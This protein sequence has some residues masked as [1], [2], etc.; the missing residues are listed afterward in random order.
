[1]LL[2]FYALRYQFLKTTWILVFHCI[3]VADLVNLTLYSSHNVCV[4]RGIWLRGKWQK[5]KPK[6]KQCIWH[7]SQTKRDTRLLLPVPLVLL[8]PHPDKMG[9]FPKPIQIMFA[10]KA[11]GEWKLK[12]SFFCCTC[13]LN[14]PTTQCYKY[15]CS[16]FIHHKWLFKLWNVGLEKKEEQKWLCGCECCLYF[17]GDAQK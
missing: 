7:K 10:G 12:D 9:C 13:Y 1:M 16:L 15:S 6:Y 11:N 3:W 2:Q 14:G 17:Y 8:Y 4:N 5:T